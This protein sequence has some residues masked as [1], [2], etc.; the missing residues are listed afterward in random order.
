MEASAEQDSGTETQRILPGGV[1]LVGNE[2]GGKD[3]LKY[4]STHIF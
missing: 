4:I 2:E 1:G 3:E